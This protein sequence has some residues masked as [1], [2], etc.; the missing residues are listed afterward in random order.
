MDLQN[1]KCNLINTKKANVRITEDKKCAICHKSI[2]D[3]TV[4]IYPNGVVVD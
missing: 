3:K 1:V 2:G 4:C